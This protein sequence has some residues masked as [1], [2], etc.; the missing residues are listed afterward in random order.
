MILRFA[1][2]TTLL[3]GCLA[4]QTLTLE[5]VLRGLEQNYPPLLAALLERDVASGANQQALGQFD[6]QLGMTAG[7]DQFGFYP[8]ERLDLG[9]S[10]NLRWQGASVYGGWR[11]GW[12]DFPPYRGL[13]D[14]RNLGEFRTGIKLPILRGRQIDD[15]SACEIAA[16]QHHAK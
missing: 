10:Q 9:A 15:P 1:I 2:W 6:T 13:D 3:A 7:S 16:Q 4:A 5:E 11:S 8:N 12:G 14:T